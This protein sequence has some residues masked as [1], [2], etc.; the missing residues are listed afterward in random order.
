VEELELGAHAAVIA[1]ARLLDPREVEV[2]L[3]L[4]GERGAVDALQ[5]RLALVAAPIRAGRF[6]Q[7]HRADLARVL[8]VGPAA[9]VHEVAV[10]EDRDGL[11]GRNVLEARELERLAETGE[12]SASVLAAH[13]LALERRALRQDL[14]H[15][16]LDALEVLGRERSLDLE[17]VLELVAVVLAADVDLDAREE[18]LHRVGHQVLGRVAQHLARGRVAHRHDLERGVGRK[19]R[20]QVDQAA[21]DARRDGVACEAAPDALRGVEGRGSRRQLERPPVG[22]SNGHGAHDRE[23]DMCGMEPSRKGRTAFLG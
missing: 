23:L 9:Q 22:Q 11:A 21:V 13:D 5:H 8:D 17:V 6:E 16:R 20:A 10:A 4:R 2:E 3:L 18:A 15:L 7:L 19:P 12:D 14:A 1:A